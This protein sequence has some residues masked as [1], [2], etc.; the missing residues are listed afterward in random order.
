VD[1]ALRVFRRTISVVATRAESVTVNAAGL[2]QGIA[3]VTFPAASTIFTARGSYDLSSSQYGVMFVPQVCTAITASLLGAGLLWPGLTARVR[4]KTIYLTGLL[5]DL[6]A[7]LLLIASWFVVHQHALSYA[8]LLTATGCLGAGFGL[9]VPSLNTL[10]AAFHPLA[11]DKSVLVLNALLGLGTA[12]A[13]VFVAVF[14]GLGFWTG[15]PW[16]AAGLLAVLIAVSLRLPLDPVVSAPQPEAR[17]PAPQ[18]EARG[19]AP[20][21]EARRPAPGRRI[22]AGFWIFAV[23]AAL[24]GF[25]E[26]MN[27][28]WSQLDITSLGG[29]AA[30]AS[31][32]L[33]GFWAMVTAGR[34]LIAAVQRWLPSR[35]A[36]HGL[37]FVLA[38]AF[39]LI[40]VLPRNATV[41]AVA[42]F[43]LAGLG[44]SALLPLTISFGQ[45]KLAG[46]Q[47]V[48][49]GGVI[50][51][52]QA[53][54][55]VA[56]FG[57]GPLVS[58]GIRLSVLFA[59]SAAVAVVMGGLS[60]LVAR[61]RPSPAAV[62]PRPA[63]P[64]PGVAAAAAHI[65]PLAGVKEQ[66]AGHHQNGRRD[67]GPAER[68][69][70][71][72]RA[73]DGAE[74]DA[75]LAQ[76]G[77]RG[78]RA[79]GL[80]P[81]HQ[82]VGEHAQRPGHH[83]GQQ[84]PARLLEQHVTPPGEGEHRD[85]EALEQHQPA[86]VADRTVRQPHAHPVHRGVRRDREAGADGGQEGRAAWAPAAEDEHGQAARDDEHP[87]DL[88][89]G[90]VLVQEDR[91][92]DRDHQRGR[93]AG[94]RV[95]LAELA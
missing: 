2:V 59:A 82:A 48:V 13:P 61:G 72:E 95:D 85:A 18:P 78:Q 73:D 67:A 24:Y 46:E 22:P 9:T 39:T 64:R 88:G 16:L 23:F 41:V 42:A 11:V 52:Y 62:H 76:R 80:G 21:P 87:G 51:C 60:L 68:L 8:L 55:G 83:A 5:A 26:T 20:Q 3:L 93:A 12:L 58:A 69:A 38:G 70:E 81:E 29:S 37:P 35:A 71:D 66:D 15:L 10:A 7:M 31:L 89:E 17:G 44:C 19:P 27:G 36:Y 57:V 32:A 14:T 28:N 33:T 43:C 74:D 50:A 53:G 45:E 79:P 84:D 34:V 47:A 40:A 77:D 92:Q 86:D 56:A 94:Q 54:Y 90:E 63:P 30:S 1:D 49:A 65:N 25:C 4:E 75:R 6:A 91:S